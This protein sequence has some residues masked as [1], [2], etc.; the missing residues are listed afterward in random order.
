MFTGVLV[1]SGNNNEAAV[2]SASFTE[3]DT[4][5]FT[6]QTNNLINA[7]GLY[8]DGTF[9]AAAESKDMIDTAL[10]TLLNAKVASLPIPNVTSSRLRNDIRVESGEFNSQYIAD[11]AMLYKLLGMENEYSFTFEVKSITGEAIDCKL[12]A[13]VHA[14][15]S[16]TVEIPFETNYVDTDLR[17]AGYEKVVNAGANGTGVEN[18]AYVYYDD[19]LIEESY[20]ST[21]VT[22]QPT[23]KVIERG[24]L[25]AN[26]SVNSLGILASPYN[27][28]LSSGYGYREDGFH[29]GIDIVAISGS[30]KGHDAYASMNGTVI[31]AG[32]S[33]GLG[34]NVKIDNGNG[35]IITY[36]HLAKVA[37]KTGQSV[38]TGDV[39]G[40]IGA[41]GRASGPHLHFKVEYNGKSVNPLLYLKLN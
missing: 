32:Y 24:V 12:S 18:Y 3:E 25:N 26:K 17:T 6:V 22:D 29:D 21:E 16:K 31:F 15:G 1:F 34:N 36:G 41:T 33:S 30:C 38:Q 40:Q 11:Q 5:A 20:V 9:I 4:A 7:Y 23:D 2:Q 37:V 13:E 39:V 19:A 10:N 27:G 35:L 14:T 8:I 28:K